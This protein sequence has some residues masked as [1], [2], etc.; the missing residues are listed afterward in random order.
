MEDL[1]SEIATP[2]K[3]TLDDEPT[4][5]PFCINMITPE[6]SRDVEGD[7][8]AT[9]Q[10]SCQVTFD[11]VDGLVDWM[12]LKSHKDRRLTTPSTRE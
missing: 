10:L 11:W 7:E 8:A 5:L 1:L 9:A 2:Q 3:C 4:A 12:L 6:Q